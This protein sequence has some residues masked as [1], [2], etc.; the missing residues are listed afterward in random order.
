VNVAVVGM[1]RSDLVVENARIAR[2]FEPMSPAEL[3]ALRDRIEPEAD[4]TLEWYK[5]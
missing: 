2:E 5:T 4:L 1:E 3:Q